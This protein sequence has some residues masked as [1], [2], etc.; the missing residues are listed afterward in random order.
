MNLVKKFSAQK[1]LYIVI[2]LWA[3]LQ[4]SFALPDN[5]V[6]DWLGWRQAD[7]QTIASNFMQPGSNIFYPQINWGGN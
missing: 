1:V 7:T 3:L 2:F 5:I 4:L 6:N